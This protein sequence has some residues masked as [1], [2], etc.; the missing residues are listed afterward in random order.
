MNGSLLFNFLR[1]LD[2]LNYDKE[3]E[4]NEQIIMVGHT[5]PGI[6]IVH[7]CSNDLMKEKW[8]SFDIN[9]PIGEVMF[10]QYIAPIIYEIQEYAGC[11]YVYLFAA[12]TSEDENFINYY[13]AALKFEQPAK[14]GTNKPRYDLCCV[15]MCQDVNELRKNRHE[16]FD[17][18]N[19]DDD[20]I[21]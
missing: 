9:R 14:V 15:F 8:K 16:Y 21:V 18:F 17:D 20:I 19:L 13:N 4:E 2:Q 7:F 6:E 12:D 10:W 3:H 5:Y 1:I 11:Q